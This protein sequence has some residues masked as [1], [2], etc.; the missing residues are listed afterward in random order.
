MKLYTFKP[1]DD[2]TVQELASVVGTFLV[3]LCEHLGGKEVIG[4]EKFE[5]E[6]SIYKNLDKKLMRHF[7]ESKDG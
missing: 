2:I 7:K 5:I 6:E 3:A 4:K 1:T